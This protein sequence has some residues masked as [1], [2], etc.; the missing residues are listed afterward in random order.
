L[1]TI[2]KSGSQIIMQD[3]LTRAEHGTLATS[4]LRTAELE[5]DKR[6]RAEL[7][8]IASQYAFLAQNLLNRRAALDFP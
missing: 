3:D 4:M 7:V 6:R 2:A 1:S 8:H 5:A